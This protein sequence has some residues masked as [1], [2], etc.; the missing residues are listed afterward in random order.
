MRFKAIYKVVKFL[1]NNQFDFKLTLEK[2]KHYLDLLIE[3]KGDYLWNPLGYEMIRFDEW[4]M[5]QFES[6]ER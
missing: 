4:F 2:Q 5:E 1:G 6:R 3:G